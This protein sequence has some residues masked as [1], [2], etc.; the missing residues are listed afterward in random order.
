[1]EHALNNHADHHYLRSGSSDDRSAGFS[2]L[3]RYAVLNSQKA[4]L[5]KANAKPGCK[6]ALWLPL[7]HPAE[8]AVPFH[9][10]SGWWLYE[11]N[12]NNIFLCGSKSDCSARCVGGRVINDVNVLDAN[13]DFLSMVTQPNTSDSAKKDKHDW[14][15]QQ[16][17]VPPSFFDSEKALFKYAIELFVNELDRDTVAI[18]RAEGVATTRAYNYY[19]SSD[20]IQRRNRIQAAMSYPLFSRSLRN[21]WALRQ[22]VDQSSSLAPKIA[23]HFQI[24]K[25]TIKSI[26]KL[27]YSNVSKYAD[28]TLIKRLD[29]YSV[30]YLPK[31]EEDLK[32]FSA[33]IEEIDALAD[34]LQIAPVLLAK[35]FRKGWKAGVDYLEDALTIKLNIHSVFEMMSASYLYGVRPLLAEHTDIA[36]MDTPPAKWYAKWFSDYSLKT[37][38]QLAELW[39]CKRDIICTLFSMKNNGTQDIAW[40]ALLTS[41]YSDG[42]YRMVELNTYGGLLYEGKNMDHCSRDYAIKCLCSGSF[43]Y[44]IRDNIG[45]ALSTVEIEFVN[46]RGSIAQHNGKN[47]SVPST[48]ESELVNRFIDNVLN[49]M[50][51]RKIQDTLEKKRVVGADI[52]KVMGTQENKRF[53]LSTDFIINNQDIMAFTHPKDMEKEDIIAYFTQRG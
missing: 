5:F 27:T 23:E 39:Q 53:V 4:F 16:N 28:M 12:S 14:V 52:L 10:F 34:L 26:R 18:L 1:V 22:A 29:R 41:T 13:D 36:P 15:F 42:D 35:P 2:N 44:A 25:R 7:A 49:T 46:G 11:S 6:T 19:V 50:P 24:Q 3:Q 37:L 20:P 38:L 32:I 33:L 45:R 40:P 9:G 43:I 47:N 51:I 21:S 48:L 31:T 17:D 30:E 8:L